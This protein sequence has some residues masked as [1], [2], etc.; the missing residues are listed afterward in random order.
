M[1]VLYWLAGGERGLLAAGPE[2]GR[3]AGSGDTA[4]LY[5]GHSGWGVSGGMGL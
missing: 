4:G 2:A 3:Y 1:D 5:R